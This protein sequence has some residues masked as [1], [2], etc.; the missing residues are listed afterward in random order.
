[1]IATLASVT[2]RGLLN[3]RRTLLL[4]LF[5]VLI[6]GVAALSRLSEPTESD[7]IE[8]TGR[9]LADFGL[10]VLLPRVAVIVGT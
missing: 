3:R 5:G 10:A 2:L 1:M 4:V 9:L 8:F 6:V 7:A